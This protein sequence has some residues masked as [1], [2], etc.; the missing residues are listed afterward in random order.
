MHGRLTNRG[1]GTGEIDIGEQRGFLMEVVTHRIEAGRYHSANIGG[2]TVDDVESHGGAEIYDDDRSIDLPLCY[3]D[4]V[5]EPVGPDLRRVGKI[6][7]H[8]K[9]NAM[10]KFDDFFA[11]L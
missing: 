10:G 3:R 4:G 5:G 1:I 8:A 11:R 6:H 9:R 7:G 2:A